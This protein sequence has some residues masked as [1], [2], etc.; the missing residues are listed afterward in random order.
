MRI[1][2]ALEVVRT[3]PLR[4]RS[5]TRPFHRTAIVPPPRR[6]YIPVTRP[7][8]WATGTPKERA[9]MVR[10]HYEIYDLTGENLC[11]LFGLTLNGLVEIVRGMDWRPEYSIG[12]DVGSVT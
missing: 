11:E 2:E 7:W 6:D 3:M 4:R 12:T 9:D 8:T 1:E 10:R 5:R